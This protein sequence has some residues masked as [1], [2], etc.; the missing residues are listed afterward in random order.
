M[1]GRIRG[2][3]LAWVTVCPT[4][5]VAAPSR[6]P[7]AQPR[8]PGPAR[9]SQRLGGSTHPLPA[10]MAAPG[11]TGPAE[12]RRTR[13]CEGSCTPRPRASP[14][15]LQPSPRPTCFRMH[16]VQRGR[17]LAAGV[18][19]RTLRPK[20]APGRARRMDTTLRSHE[21]DARSSSTE[22][23][24]SASCQASHEARFH[25]NHGVTS[26]FGPGRVVE[27]RLTSSPTGHTC[28]SRLDMKEDA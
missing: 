17:A 15:P 28:L 26:G 8:K 6:G 22:A 18:R 3:N 7:G 23:G 25:R 2:V 9:G 10:A 21:R 13:T 5:R 12:V 14:H 11:K 16:R 27:R 1:R 19:A 20:A 4:G 24:A